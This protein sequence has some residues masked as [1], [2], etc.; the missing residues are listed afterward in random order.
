MAF[1][2]ETVELTNL[3]SIRELARKLLTSDLG[4]IAAIVCNAGMGGWTGIDW[5]KAIPQMLA[6]FRNNTV[7]PSF[8]LGAIGAI[9]KPQFPVAALSEPEPPLGEIFCANLF[10]HYMLVHWLMPLLRVR[11]SKDPCKIIWVSSIEPQDA[12]FQESDLQGLRT[13]APYEHSKRMTD[14]LSLSANQVTTLPSTMSFNSPGSENATVPSSRRD[15]SAP[16]MHVFHPGV[17]VT[18]VISLIW[19]VQYAYLLGIYMARWIGSPWST[20][21]PYTAAHGATWLALATEEEI[22]RAEQDAHASHADIEPTA[23]R[24]RVKWGTSVTVSGRSSVKA[25]EV[26]KWG[27]NGSGASYATTWWAGSN[28]KGRKPGAVEANAENVT[29]FIAQG[30]RV[31]EQME[32]LRQQWQKRIDEAERTK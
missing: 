5:L 22:S 16:S 29:E 32:Q 7:W 9:T 15:R 19:I 1:Q 30:A 3:L 26:D 10:G 2:S 21:E 25:T 12:S 31:W 6:D 24:G 11:S 8:K 17:V 4:G 28:G 18:S 13:D 14:L 20:V 27:I 23:R